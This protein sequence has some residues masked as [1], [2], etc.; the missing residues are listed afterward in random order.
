MENMDLV[1]YENESQLK[2]HFSDG[3]LTLEILKK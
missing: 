2:V 1:F 3:L